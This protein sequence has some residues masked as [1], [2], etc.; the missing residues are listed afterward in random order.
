MGA[1]LIIFMTRLVFHKLEESKL[2]KII[3]TFLFVTITLTIIELLGG[4]LIEKVFDEVFWDYTHHRFSM[5]PY[6]S[7]E[8]SILWGVVSLLFSYIIKPKIDP[9]IKK[10]PILITILVLIIFLI[11]LIKTFI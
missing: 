3:V 2:K 11:D 1:V 8:M 7:L 10:I 5:G 4:I 6:I 9:L